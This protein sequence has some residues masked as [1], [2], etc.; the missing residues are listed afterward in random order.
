MIRERRER[1]RA[2]F[3]LIEL[4]VVIFILA[5]G[6]TSVASLFIAGVVS[7]RQ[8]ER[9]SAAT[10][11]AQHQMEKARALGFGNCRV[12]PDIFPTTD[13]YEIAVMNADQTGSLDFSVPQLPD[14]HG[15]L[16]I[17]YYDPGTGP[18]ANLKVITVTVIWSGADPTS[19]ETVL[20]SYLA[21]RP[22]S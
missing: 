13:G 20:T 2:G 6:L 10:Y 11:E 8:A 12:D 16:S 9:I 21:N 15:T 22:K 14:G 3:S 19:G 7:S 17:E 1:R 4:I 18:Y 5:V